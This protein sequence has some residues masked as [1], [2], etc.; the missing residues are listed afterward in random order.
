MLSSLSFAVAG[1]FAVA[2]AYMVLAVFGVIRFA[3]KL[4][5]K[6][7]QAHAWA[8]VT[9]LKPLCGDE[10]ELYENLKSFCEQ[11]YPAYQV[12]F[13]V[14]DAGDPAIAVAERLIEE[15][16]GKDLA[17]V[18][19]ERVIGRNLKVANL[20]N[21]FRR[22]RHDLIVVADSD[23]RVGR[24]Y[25]AAVAGTFTDPRVGAATCLYSG[26]GGANLASRLGAMFINDWFLPSALIP[27][28]FGELKFCF[29]ATMAVRRA[30]LSEIGGFE[31]LAS[32]LADDY[33][34]GHLVAERGHKVALAPY[35][36]ENRV[37]EPGL[38]ALFKHETRWARTIRSV[39]P[40]GYAL[41]FVTEALAVSLA[42]AWATYELTG[43]APL[44]AVPVAATLMLRWAL[45][46]AAQRKLAGGRA[47]S[48]W[49]IPVRDAFSLAVRVGSFFGR[50]VNWRGQEMT[51]GAESRLDPLT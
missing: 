9:V 14:R 45:H 29:G 22:A 7:G 20:A 27:T 50:G 28:M 35:V 48:P 17:L 38:K 12:I 31:A 51:V 19:D 44:A 30:A 25:L 13:G 3:R 23:M 43:S 8:P 34:L 32:V 24:G 46:F 40:G 21:M 18:V 2:L 5:H 37:H 4:G 36:V 10:P 6:S 33:M 11:D 39:Q 49:L 42:A 41:S 47:Y 1:V 16:P 26:A 15:F